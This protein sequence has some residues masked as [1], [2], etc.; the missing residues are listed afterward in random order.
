LVEGHSKKP[1]LDGGNLQLVGR[2]DTDWIVVFEGAENM[3]GEF[4]KV[5][6]T[7]S[8]PLTLFGSPAAD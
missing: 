7:R 3:A 5:K 2:T 4:V 1:H 8:S 6:I